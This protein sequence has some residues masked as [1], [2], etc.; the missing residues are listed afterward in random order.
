MSVG[1]TTECPA[2]L[3]DLAVGRQSTAIA[4]VADEVPVNSGLVDAAGLGI[5][6]AE[7]EVD[8]AADLLV[9]QDRA[10]RAVDPAVRADADLAEA[11]RA[12]IGRERALQV[13]VTS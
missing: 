11:A 3:Q 5:G 7:R 10:D 13:L 9:E 6:A 1:T 8:G 12:R 4:Q 2:L